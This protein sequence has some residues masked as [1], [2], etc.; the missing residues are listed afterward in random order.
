MQQAIE[1]D[2]HGQ[3]IRGMVY[4]PAGAG[5]RRCALLLHS[6]TGDRIENG[7]LFVKLGRT[8]AQQGIA[9][10][11]FDFL[12]SGESDGAFEEM[13][14]TGELA[15]TL[16]MVQWAQGQP[17][18]DRTRWASSVIPWAAC[19]P[20][21]PSGSLP[22][23]R[24]LALIAPTTVRNLC[25]RSGNQES[26]APTQQPVIV[27]PHTLHPRVFEDLRSLAPLTF[28]ELVRHPRPTLVVQ[29]TGDT[30]VPVEVS[31]EFIDALRQANI[32]YEVHQVPD[33]EHNFIRLPWQQS[34]IDAVVGWMGTKL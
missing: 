8:L 23:L 25:R 21:A 20:P 28:T 17:F 26:C 12:N 10:I 19:W 22:D 27:G 24:A 18:V 5:R 29:G 4:L 11:T 15:D 30:S 2:H 32:P 33:A 3:T 6:F 14:P 9:A 16:R 34:L 7:S 13:L 1:V 31:Q